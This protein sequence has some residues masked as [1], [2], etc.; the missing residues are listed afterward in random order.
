MKNMKKATNLGKHFSSEHRR[1]LSESNKGK[2]HNISK[3][4]REKMRRRM[5]GKKGIGTPH[6]KHGLSKTKEYIREKNHRWR[7]KNH[8]RHIWH[9]RNRRAILSG[10][11]G[12]HTMA[13]WETL[14]AQYNWRCPRCRRG[15]PEIRLV[16]DHIVPVVLG[17]SNNIENI[18]PLCGPCNNWKRTKI[19]KL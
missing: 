10:N 13:E 7:S 9:N 17:G 16:A 11:G 6:F 2:E 14:K 4:N 15:E 1:K 19:I 12:Y 18:Q 3:E 8:E 5:L